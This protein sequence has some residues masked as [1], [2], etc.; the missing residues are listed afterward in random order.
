M[1]CGLSDFDAG[2]ADVAQA[3]SLVFMQA[4]TEQGED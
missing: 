2:I 4:S 3:E 1:G